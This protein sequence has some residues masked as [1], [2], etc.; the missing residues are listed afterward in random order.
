MH[1]QTAGALQN[2]LSAAAQGRGGTMAAESGDALDAVDGNPAG[3]A[4]LQGKSFEAGGVALL[5]TGSFC[6]SVSSGNHLHGGAGAIPYGVFAA[7][8]GQSPWRVAL[9]VTPDTLIL[10]NWRYQDPAGTLGVTYGLAEDRSEIVAIRTSAAL[11]WSVG[12]RLS[13]GVT[14]A[15][16]YNT[17]SLKSPYIFQQQ[18]ALAGLKVLLDLDTRGFGW[19]GSA[20]AQWRP[21]G[22]LGFGAAWKS[23]TYVQSHGDA[24][25]SA[26]A[27]FAALGV[28]ADPAFH[29]RAE[30]DNHFPQTATAGMYWQARPRVRIGV[31]GDWVGWSGAF[32]S[33]PVKLKDG[34][35][36]VINSVAGSSSLRDQVSL[37][38]RNQGVLRAGL[39]VSV[40]SRWAARGGYSFMSDPVPSA[41]LT[42][43]TAAILRNALSAGAGWSR[44]RLGWDLAYQAQLPNSASTG[45]SGLKAG[46]YNN[47]RV[48]VMTQSIT[49]T[50]RMKF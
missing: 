27:L 47:T 13:A 22:K 11:A 50:A 19:N 5:A 2:G 31:E 42:P 35:N 1:A 49:F 25:G 7:R 12:H 37:D 44:E 43:M 40:A 28:T 36:A 48:S 3:L 32:H 10:V 46:E 21:T 16:D 23:G 34:T 4:T 9:A 6:N 30:V 26:S 29:Y 39:E 41:T 45:I 38:W 18:P 24:S 20:G 17:N 8:L 14:F 15:S 33:L